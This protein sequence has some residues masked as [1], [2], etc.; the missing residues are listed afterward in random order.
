MKITPT[1]GCTVEGRQP[2]PTSF[3]FKLASLQISKEV[4]SRA[5]SQLNGLTITIKEPI[6]KTF[7]G[8]KVK[9]GHTFL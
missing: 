1:L 3:N 8:L 6:S 2:K 5:A 9:S 4:Y 7:F